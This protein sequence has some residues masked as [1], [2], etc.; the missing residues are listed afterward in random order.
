[1]SMYSDS[2]CVAPGIDVEIRIVLNVEICIVVVVEM[3]IV[4]DA[5]ILKYKVV[6]S[7]IP[8]ITIIHES[9]STVI[10]TEPSAPLYNA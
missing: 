5:E 10:D 7:T 4:I 8:Q 6:H 2:E 9:L 3:R 1:M